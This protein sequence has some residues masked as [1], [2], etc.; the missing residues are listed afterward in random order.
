M[1]PTRWE[2][3]RL[4]RGVGGGAGGDDDDDNL[5]GSQSDPQQLPGTWFLTQCQ[6]LLKSK[7]NFD[8]YIVLLC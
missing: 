5:F 4:G 8:S 7:L 1:I 3:S 2:D 6:H